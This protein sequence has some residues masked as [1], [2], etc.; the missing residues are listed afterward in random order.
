VT[1]V[2]L[3]TCAVTSPSA[4]SHAR[5][6]P[7]LARELAVLALLYVG[8]SLSRLLVDSGPQ[9][10]LEHGRQ[11]LAWER[12]VGLD[13]EAGLV[14][15]LLAS[16]ALSIGAGYVYATLH[17]T[18]TPAVLVWL[19][20]RHPARYG[21]ARTVL[22]AATVAALVG[23]WLYPTAPPRL[24]PHAGFPDVLAL[25]ADWGWWGTDASAPRGLGA[26]TNE[27]AAM[28]S[29]HVG[30]AVW[31]GMA[32]A[33]CARRPVVRALGLAYPV[34]ITLVVVATANH[35]LLDAVAGAV[36]VAAVAALTVMTSKA[37]TGDVRPLGADPFP[38][39][40]PQRRPGAAS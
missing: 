39:L 11:V 26:L 34:L 32:L 16:P 12:Q 7:Q 1:V 10:A 31:S 22:A 20:R 14:A 19:H 30:W 27:Y 18:V 13:V 37:R 8:Y 33:L 6:R 23:F 40:P 25:V 36:V 3:N 15:W 17:Y 29:M 24:L 28:P 2:D 35:Y 9:A 5:R 4:G 21:P 38:A